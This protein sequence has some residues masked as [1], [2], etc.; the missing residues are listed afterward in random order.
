M[1][2][3]L[4][5]S[6]ELLSYLEGKKN[7]LAFSA[8][9]DSSALFFLLIEHHIIF[10]IALVNYGLREQSKEEEAYALFL[11]KEYNLQVYTIQAPSFQ[12]NFE[13][14]ARDFRY[15][16]FDELMSKYNYNNLL[17]AHQLNDQLE[18]LLMRLTKGA[19]TSELLGLETYSARKEYVLVRPL[20]EYS[21]DELL[22]YL[23]SHNHHYF[24]DESNSNNKY[25]RN[26]FRNEF[27]NK[28][29]DNYA[30][31]IK[32]SFKYLKEDKEILNRGYIE[33]FHDKEL[34]VLSY[35]SE[36]LVVRLVDKYLKRLGY[37]LSGQQRAELKKE[38][39]LVFGHLWAVE[40]QEKYIFIAPYRTSAMPKKFK[41]ICRKLK[42]P[43]KVR[44]YL[45]EEE[46]EPIVLLNSF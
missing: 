10:D 43:I 35:E 34:Y 14:N 38:T 27:S 13:K 17:T 19:G 15:G 41:E 3:S 22:N 1:E 30:D 46:I 6:S 21:K 37:L 28:L 33:L 31:G 29:I 4:K 44:A 40:I 23:K 16:F 11:A 36:H 12:Q 18:W 42:I 2:H 45:N 32:K 25:E 20:L 39:S 8:G 7:L 26:L 5:L 24:V 9:V